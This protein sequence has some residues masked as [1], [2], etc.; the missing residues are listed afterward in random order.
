MTD[1]NVFFSL[2]WIL[3]SEWVP[4]EWVQT[5]DENL[6]VLH[7]TPVH[8]LKSCEAKSC[9]FE[10]KKSIKKFFKHQTFASS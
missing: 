3:C 1:V 2:Q 8:Q 9:M 5:A 6:T 7:T 10:R 4:S